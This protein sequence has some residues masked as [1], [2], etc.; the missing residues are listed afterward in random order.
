MTQDLK[1]LRR[2]MAY[3]LFDLF[4]DEEV[5]SSTIESAL[6]QYALACLGEPSE[7][8]LKAANAQLASEAAKL[9]LTDKSILNADKAATGYWNAMAA[10]RAREIE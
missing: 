4:I 5:V 6:L 2:E 9:W 1:A 8:M 7:R 10:Q 3:A